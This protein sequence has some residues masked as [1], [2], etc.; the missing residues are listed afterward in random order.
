M[1][2]PQSH[3]LE[4]TPRLHYLEW[5]QGGRVTLVALHG[6]SANAW[7]WQ[8]VAAAMAPGDMRLIALDQRGHGDSEWVRPPAYAPSDYA[9]DLARFLSA[10][11]LERP[12]VV[13]HSMGG[14]SVIAFAMRYPEAARAAVAIDVAVTSSH[15]RNRYLRRL[16]ALPTVAYPD[17]ETAKARFRLMPDEGEIPPATLARIA[18]KSLGRTQAGAYTMKFDRESFFGSDGIDVSDALQH[19]QVPLLLVRAGMSRIMTAEA[20]QEA[21]ASNPFVRLVEIPAT[22]HHMLLERPDLLA[23]AIAEFVSALS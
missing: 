11:R 20:A 10:L 16:K 7:W 21:A 3:F 14:I 4:G 15:R 13:G 6:N 17:F 5:N 22:H 2:A 12:I 8:P 23:S 1:T 9:G 18:E 19:V